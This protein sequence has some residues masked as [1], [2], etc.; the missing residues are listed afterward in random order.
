MTR[1]SRI[2]PAL[3]VLA[4]APALAVADETIPT[5]TLTDGVVSPQQIYLPA[6]TA[7]TLTVSNT[8]KTAAEFESKRLR[9]EK[10]IAPGQT[11]TIEL[12]ALPAGSYPFVEEFHEDQDTAKGT[13]VV[14]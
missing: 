2:L 4:C 6:D 14:K 1:I 8:G 3:F 7:V 10:I 5:I 9:I 11:E 12:R 13:I